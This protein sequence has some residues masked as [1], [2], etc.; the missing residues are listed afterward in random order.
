M[1]G[2]SVRLA[3]VQPLNRAKQKLGPMGCIQDGY[4]SSLP[5]AKAETGREASLQN[6]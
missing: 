1:R 6:V 5:A 2:P 4:L 3:A